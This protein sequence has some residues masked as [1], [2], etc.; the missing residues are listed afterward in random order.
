MH[1]FIQKP[2]IFGLLDEYLLNYSAELLY[3][4]VKIIWIKLEELLEF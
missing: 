1:Q 3:F 4:Q 2:S